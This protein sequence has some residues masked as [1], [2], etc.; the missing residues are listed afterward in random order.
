MGIRNQ[1][2]GFTVEQEKAMGEIVA[3]HIGANMQ[4]GKDLRGYPWIAVQHGPAL[5]VRW[6]VFHPDGTMVEQTGIS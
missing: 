4:T 1:K 6:F 3:D 5:R 2:T